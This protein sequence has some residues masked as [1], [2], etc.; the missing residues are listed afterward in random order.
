MVVPI[1]VLKAVSIVH[2]D[3]GRG[4][5]RISDVDTALMDLSLVALCWLV[6]RRRHLIG[7]D[8]VFVFFVLV[9]AATTTALLSYVVTNFGTMFRMR[10]TA[11]APLWTLALAIWPKLSSCAPEA[12]V[13]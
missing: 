3:G 7:R 13:G 6:L 9:L 4:L 11:V 8:G 12:S 1:S 2:F 5:L 10:S